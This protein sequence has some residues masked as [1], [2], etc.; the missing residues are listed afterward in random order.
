MI[1]RPSKKDM[2]VKIDKPF[3]R[4]TVTKG[5]RKLLCMYCVISILPIFIHLTERSSDTSG[6]HTAI[7]RVKGFKSYM[8]Q[9]LVLSS[10]KIPHDKGC[11][12][13]YCINPGIV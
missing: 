4:V 1:N 3:M 6:L 12:P 7:Y 5:I 13:V 2:I 10:S 9:R 11:R 8:G